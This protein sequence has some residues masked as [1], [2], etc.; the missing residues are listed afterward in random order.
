MDSQIA[1]RLRA[2]APKNSLAAMGRAREFSFTERDFQLIR[3]H[4]YRRAGIALKAG[5]Q[6]MVYSRLAR[7]LRALNLA[8]FEQY[9]ALLEDDESP[10]WQPF[11]NAI[12]TNLTYF[13]R[14]PH[15]FALLQAQLS[16]LDP[17]QPAQIW[18]AGTATGEEAYSL[19]MTVLETFPHRPAPVSVFASDLDTAAL[20]VAEAGMY[21]LERLHNVS[22]AR[23]KR[24]FLRGQGPQAGLVKVKQE[25]R[26]LVTFR[27]LNLIEPHW[28][29]ERR[30]HAIF[31]RNV[32]IYFDKE[33]QYGILEKL[34]ASLAPA[35]LLYAGH[36]E[37]FFHAKDLFQL[38]ER[39]VY[40]PL[41]R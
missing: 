41:P 2:S 16:A 1:L 35:G 3:R 34:H 8:T 5:K 13:F 37:N 39:T 10:E 21:R 29:S 25:V 6:E 20:A 18:S 26:R 22:P 7:R 12:T 33:T 4:I 31:C 11:V 24:F 28:R 23:L 30:F 32:M 14:E 17:S 19:A 9:L 15:H 27:R 38:R 40:S 36:S